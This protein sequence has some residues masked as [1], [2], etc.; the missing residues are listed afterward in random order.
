MH[1]LVYCGKSTQ[2]C[3]SRIDRKIDENL[4]LNIS[5]KD[6]NIVFD[7]NVLDYADSY[8]LQYNV[9]DGD[10]YGIAYKTAK[11]GTC[12]STADGIIVP[13]YEE[14]LLIYNDCWPMYFRLRMIKDDG[15]IWYSR[16]IEYTPPTYT[17]TFMDGATVVGTR[18]AM[19]GKS[20]TPPDLEKEGY[21]LSWN[22]AYDNVTADV[23]I[24]AV[25]TAIPTQK[26]TP[27]KPIS[28]PEETQSSQNQTLPTAGTQ[29]EDSSAVYKVTKSTASQKEVT[30]VKP[31]S[32]NKTSVS[33]PNT[34]KISG[35]TYKVTSVAANALA[36]NKKVT[37]VTIG[38]NVTSIGKNA[39]KKCT[40]LKTVTLKSTSLKSIGS[41]AFYGDKNLKT[42]TIKSSKLTSKSVGKN[43][44]KGT[45]KKL[46][47]KVPKKKVSSYKKFL[48]KKGNK[49]ITVKK[50]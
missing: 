1:N 47:I 21:T 28:Q 46:T 50:G 45:N 42:I 3:E 20:V 2:L 16:R 6:D 33:I 40:K 15:T 27:Q 4:N 43:A 35:F 10:A 9:V 23:I 22:G 31:K 13:H 25:W 17:V 8:E 5:I 7:W 24:Y 11:D 12:G 36:N 49:K 18:T 19:A 30:Y 38:K 37:K 41:N 34:V 32:K 29:M 48:K 44:F 14:S 26:P 39:F